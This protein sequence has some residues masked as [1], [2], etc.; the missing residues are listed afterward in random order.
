MTDVN[1]WNVTDASNNG[2]P[3]AGA[4]EGMAP[5]GVNDVMRAIMGGVARLFAD[6]NSTLDSGGSSNAYTLTPNQ[7]FSAYARGDWFVFE[8]NHTN[9]GAATMNVSALG[10]QSI[11]NPD[12]G[13]LS[14]GAI[15]SGGVYTIFYDGTNFQ[16]LGGASAPT[17]DTVTVGFL[18]FGAAPELTIVGGAITATGTYHRVDTQSD[19]STDDLGTING[20]TEGDLLILRAENSSRTVVCKD[21]VGNL[22]MAGG[23]FTLSHVDDKIMFIYDGTN[24]CEIS[25]SNNT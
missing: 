20:G 22:S 7:T 21:A 10:A 14:A 9:T 8:A 19:A 16:L 25:R 23:D 4:P 2:T 11:L 18:N 17:F 13:E 12:G 1:Q 24:W 3:P 6:T 15:T 5:S